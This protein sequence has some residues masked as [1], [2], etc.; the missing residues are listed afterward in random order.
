MS[1]G[2]NKICSKL[3]NLRGKKALKANKFDCNLNAYDQ[4]LIAN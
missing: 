1:F 3:E 2:E 4:N